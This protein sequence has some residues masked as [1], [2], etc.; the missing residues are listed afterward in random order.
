MGF[1]FG[2]K[3]LRNGCTAV[4]SVALSHGSS[5]DAVDSPSKVRMPQCNPIFEKVTSSRFWSDNREP[6]ATASARSNL[7]MITVKCGY[8]SID[9]Y[10]ITKGVCLDVHLVP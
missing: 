6:G 4:R 7:V 9:N 1:G 5:R 2:W 8:R 10:E 3:Q